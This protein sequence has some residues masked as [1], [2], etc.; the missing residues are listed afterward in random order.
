MSRKIKKHALIPIWR[1]PWLLAAAVLLV[2]ANSWSNPFILDDATH[3]LQNRRIGEWKNWTEIFREPFFLFPEAGLAQYYRPLTKLTYKVEWLLFGDRPFGYHLVNTL[4]HALN[5]IL[6]YLVCR[7]LGARAR[8]AFLAALIFGIH[9]LQTEEVSYIS[10]LGGLASVSG[11]LASL[12]CLIGFLKKRRFAWY[13]SSI[14]FFLI[15]LLYKEVAL[16]AP[17]LLVWMAL[18]ALPSGEEDRLRGPALAGYILP[19]FLLAGGYLVLRSFFLVRTDF[20]AGLTGGLWLRFLTFGKG[21]W[22]YLGLALFPFGLH[23]Y[24]SLALLSHGWHFLPLLL[25]GGCALGLARSIRPPGRPTSL[26]AFGFGSFLIGL[27]P[28]SGVN[29]IFLERGFLY[30]GEHFMYLPLAGLGMV[31][32]AAFNCRRKYPGAGPA[33]ICLALIICVM[34]FLTVRQNT[35]W[36]DETAFFERM[37]RYE[38]NLFRTAG[39]LGIAYYKEG[40]IEEAVAAD[41]RARKILIDRNAVSSGKELPPMDRYQLKIILWRVSQGF[42]SLRRYGEAEEAARELL[43][44][45][46]EGYEG[47]YLLGRALLAAGDVKGARPYLEE[48][49]R[50]QPDNFEVARALI[51]CYRRLGEDKRAQ[52]VW[53]AASRRIPAFRQARD[54]LKQ[55]Y[56]K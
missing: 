50:L 54:I 27:L 48:A 38:S 20:T 2:Y 19:F 12:Y 3:I 56:Q 36:S 45:T 39:L 42:R 47:R 6:L 53:S 8:P 52:A 5:T 32:A 55:R 13:F 43:E 35:F 41:L 46:P 26:F 33:R 10:G 34:A 31:L 44:I 28:F 49:Y 51:V 11:I 9:P 24:R 30:W 14:F 25:L 17:V 23:F 16:L 1:R 29:P 7:R 37:V 40:R 15:G 21:I 18:T 4:L 22:I